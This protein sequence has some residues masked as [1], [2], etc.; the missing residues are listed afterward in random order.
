MLNFFRKTSKSLIRIIRFVLYLFKY[1]MDSIILFLIYYRPSGEYRNNRKISGVFSPLPRINPV[2]LDSTTWLSFDV[3]TNQIDKWLHSHNDISILQDTVSEKKTLLKPVKN[4]TNIGANRF[5]AGAALQ[6]ILWRTPQCGRRK[7]QALHRGRRN[8]RHRQPSG[9]STT[10]P[11]ARRQ[12]SSVVVS[13]SPGRRTRALRS[14][15]P[16]ATRASSRARPV[17]AR[18]LPVWCRFHAPHVRAL[19]SGTMRTWGGSAT[20]RACAGAIF[21]AYT[22]ARARTAA[23]PASGKCLAGSGVGSARGGR[24]GAM[25][26]RCLLGWVRARGH[27]VGRDGIGSW[28]VRPHVAC[29]RPRAPT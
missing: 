4:T 25:I 24:P 7:R 23:S 6:N 13:P 19:G 26:A 17:R 12:K 18:C 11:V 27:L 3:K 2:L 29:R 22:S 8:E 9:L 5:R 14:R 21:P 28:A 20:L 1:I 16:A 15:A 10:A